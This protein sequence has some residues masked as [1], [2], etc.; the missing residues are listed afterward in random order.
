[1]IAYVL[2]I[3]DHPLKRLY[4]CDGYFTASASQQVETGLHAANESRYVIR[5]IPRRKHVVFEVGRGAVT[6][7]TAGVQTKIKTLPVTRR[8]RNGCDFFGLFVVAQERL[9]T[10]HR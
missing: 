8:R 2:F 7:I 5:P 4:F 6:K 10:G 9:G 3:G 1:M